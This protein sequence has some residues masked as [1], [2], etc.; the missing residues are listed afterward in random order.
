[1]G[2]T[3]DRAE[4]S[5]TGE[6]NSTVAALADLMAR[7]RGGRQISC[8]ESF[9]GGLLAHALS[10][11]EAADEWFVGGIVVHRQVLQR[12]VLGVRSPDA[13]SE[14]SAVQMALGAAKLFRTEAAVAAIGVGG[15]APSDGRAPG[16]V[17]IGWVVDG[18]W[19]AITLDLPGTP[20]EIALRAVRTALT[21]LSRAMT[22]ADDDPEDRLAATRR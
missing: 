9:T 12:E 3:L 7:R 20:D 18:R 5:R 11:A 14:G 16:T 13:L 17:L 4:T 2:G 1:M 21:S 15:P 19:G 22:E 8:A 6:L 10:A